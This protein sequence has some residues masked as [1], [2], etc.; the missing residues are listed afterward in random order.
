MIKKTEDL[1]IKY[2]SQIDTDSIIKNVNLK[3]D[4]VEF[5]KT[6]EIFYSKLNY[7]EGRSSKYDHELNMLR[8]S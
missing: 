3:A 2:R 8:V 4:E 7:L 6:V 1:F 5:R